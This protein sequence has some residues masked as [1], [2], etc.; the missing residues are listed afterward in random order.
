MRRRWRLTW[1]DSFECRV[2]G[3]IDCSRLLLHQ[4]ARAFGKR[5]VD[6]LAGQCLQDV[7]EIPGALVLSGLLHL[8]QV[9]V[10]DHLA[11]GA[12]VAVGRKEVVHPLLLHLF[13]DGR[14][15]IGGRRFH[16]FRAVT[17]SPLEAAIAMPLAPA[18]DA[19]SRNDAKSE[20][21][22][23]NT[24]LPTTSPPFSLTLS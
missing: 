14:S 1:L 17:V 16:G 8:E 10:V 20:V 12:N 7:V 3:S 21:F 6:G 15:V 23:G 4:R 11:V 2:I 5:T 24:G 9:H 19:V 18:L 13:H 22:G